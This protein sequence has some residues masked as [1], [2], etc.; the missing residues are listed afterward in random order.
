MSLV[1]PTEEDNAYDRSRRQNCGPHCKCHGKPVH[2]ALW[3]EALSVR[4]DVAG[5]RRGSDSVEQG[6]TED[7]PTC[8]A[9][10]TS[11]LA[12]PESSGLTLV[13]V[14]LVNAGNARPIPRLM[15]IC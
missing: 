13:S 5:R 10:L 14:V 12:T 8:W 1:A 9:L 11:E 2:D 15:T 4:G 6:R 7:A 3:R